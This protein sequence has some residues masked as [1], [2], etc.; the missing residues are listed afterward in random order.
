MASS[1]ARQPGHRRSGEFV[2]DVVAA[3]APAEDRERYMPFARDLY[4]TLYRPPIPD[5]S[6]R[7]KQV[8]MKYFARGLHG[9]VMWQIGDRLL[10]KLY[11]AAGVWRGR[12]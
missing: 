9:K 3:V 1:K 8:V 10:G 4:A 2:R 12:N 11:P 6:R 7:T 5:F